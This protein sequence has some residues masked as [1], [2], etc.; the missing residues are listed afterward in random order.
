MHQKS[1]RPR[2][3]ACI[4][5]STVLESPALI[6][7]PCPLDN[8]FRHLTFGPR[9]VGCPSPELPA[10]WDWSPEPVALSRPAGGHR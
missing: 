5:A 6:G 2:P 3:R 9:A 1:L 4:W 10:N 7:L 8:Q